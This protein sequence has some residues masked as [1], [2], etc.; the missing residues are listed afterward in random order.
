M[1]PNFKAPVTIQWRKMTIPPETA[2]LGVKADSNSEMVEFRLPRYYQGFDFLTVSWWADTYNAEKAIFDTTNAEVRADENDE[3]HIILKWIVSRISAFAKG[4]L[5]V[6]LRAVGTYDNG[7]D[8]VWQTETGIFQ[9]ADTFEADGLSGE[10][11]MTWVNEMTREIQAYAELA[12]Q[13]VEGLD[14]KVSEAIEKITP[15]VVKQYVAASAIATSDGGD[16]QEALDDHDA[17]VVDLEGRTA[18]ITP[19]EI[20]AI[21]TM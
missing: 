9:V 14:G 12:K 6:R 7:E 8:F 20:D 2:L 15:E 3:T 16:V 1:E 19:E 5:E 17:R 11:G 10:P 21:L 13:S 18:F 4:K